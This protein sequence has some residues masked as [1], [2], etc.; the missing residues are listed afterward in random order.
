MTYADRLELD[1]GGRRVQALHYDR[2]ITPGDTFLYL[3]AEKIVVMGDLLVNPVTFGLSSYPGGWLATLERIDRLDASV[4]IPGHG[5][6]LR[7]KTL[8]RA[9]MDV[10]RTLIA[11]GKDAKARGLDADQA[12]EEVLPRLHDVM[13]SITKDDPKLNE[14]FKVYLV[15]WTLHRV[16][17]ELNGPLTD[18]IAPIPPK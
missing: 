12:K 13:V 9:T 5:E 6:P 18:A 2:A 10:L 11:A 15:D 17:D 16:F 8:L 7:D 14:Q 1:L 4:L 3:P